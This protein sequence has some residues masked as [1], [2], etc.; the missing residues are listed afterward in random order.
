MWTCPHQNS[1]EFTFFWFSIWLLILYFPNFKILS[2]PIGPSGA[3]AKGLD[4]I[5]DLWTKITYFLSITLTILREKWAWVRL[6]SRPPGLFDCVLPRTNFIFML[7]LHLGVFYKILRCTCLKL[8]TFFPKNDDVNGD[9]TKTWFILPL[10]H[11][12]VWNFPCSKN[13]FQKIDRHPL[14]M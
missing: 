13:K 2:Q 8:T 5:S 14:V 7:T 1:T 6:T 3:P 4:V 12:F 11:L 9:S 10:A